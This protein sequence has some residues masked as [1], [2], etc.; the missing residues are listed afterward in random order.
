MKKVIVVLVV[1]CLLASAQKPPAQ[2]SAGQNK[3]QQMSRMQGTEQMQAMHEQ[4]MKD[5]QGDIDSMKATLSQMK[6]QLAKISDSSVRQQLQ[7]NVDLWQK[8][9]DNME[10]HMTMM[11]SMMESHQDMMMRHRGMMKGGSTRQNPPPP[12]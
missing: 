6:G 5:M 4:M 2:G 3:D 12:K 10:K 8:M 11:K 1:S 7:W 9:M